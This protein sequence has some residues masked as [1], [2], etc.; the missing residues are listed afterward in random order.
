MT[1]IILFDGV[2]NVCNTAIKFINSHDTKDIFRYATLQSTVGQYYLK[3][4]KLP[5]DNFSSL[6][7]VDSNQ[8]Y[9]SSNAVLRIA[10][11]LRGIIKVLYFLIW[12]PPFIRDP[13]YSKI[14]KNRFL[15]SKKLRKCHL[16]TEE[17]NKKF[18]TNIMPPE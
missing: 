15:I 11:E 1:K 2:C 10:K 13:V 3:K 5:T 16:P 8:Y 7:L 9:L 17:E 12:I 4:F 6:V 14:A 18:L